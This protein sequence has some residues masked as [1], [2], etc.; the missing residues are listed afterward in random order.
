MTTPDMCG[1]NTTR[2]GSERRERA[3]NDGAAAQPVVYI[4][5]E[6][7]N[8]PVRSTRRQS[9]HADA[10]NAA[11]LLWVTFSFYVPPPSVITL[12]VNLL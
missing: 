4:V 5:P 11:A 2:P 10:N 8:R 3:L 9:D 1:R 6:P 12:F 7:P